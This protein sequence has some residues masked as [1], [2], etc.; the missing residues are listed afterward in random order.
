MPLLDLNP[1]QAAVL[2]EYLER[3][4]SELSVE[5]AGTDRQSYLDEIKAERKELRDILNQL[6]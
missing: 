5:I 1:I 2:K 3:A 4:L 6:K